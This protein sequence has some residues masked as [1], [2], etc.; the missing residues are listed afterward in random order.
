MKNYTA[1]YQNLNITARLIL[2]LGGASMLVIYYLG[3]V[4]GGL[5]GYRDYLAIFSVIPITMAII[6]WSPVVLA[7]YERSR[8]F[9]RAASE[10][11]KPV[12][13]IRSAA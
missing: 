5:P 2:A 9:L 12:S 6:G 4:N 8:S 11:T 7:G 1:N 3:T 13:T 10:A